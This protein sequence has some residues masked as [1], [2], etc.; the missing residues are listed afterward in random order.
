MMNS[1]SRFG[2]MP[3]LLD[4]AEIQE[5][6][7]QPGFENHLARKLRQARRRAFGLYLAE[8]AA[9]F[10]TI[11]KEALDRAANDPGVDP[12]FL[13]AVLNIKFRFTVSVWLLRSSLWLP[14][15][16]LPGTHRMAVNLVG[17]LQPLLAKTR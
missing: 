12:E 5:L 11:E 16:L 8:L 13:T 6:S 17:S 1:M 4:E 14:P 2:A 7:H 15:N 10:R 3:K 9:E